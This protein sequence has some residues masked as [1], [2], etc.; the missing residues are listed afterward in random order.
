MRPMSA[1]VQCLVVS[2]TFKHTVGAEG[3]TSEGSGVSYWD[4]CGEATIIHDVKHY[5]ELAAK[6]S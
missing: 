5:R 4:P 1:A 6:L 3:A 2:A